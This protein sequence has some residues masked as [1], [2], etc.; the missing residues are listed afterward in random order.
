MMQGFRGDGVDD[1]CGR[2]IGGEMSS[3]VDV[4]RML[5]KRARHEDCVLFTNEMSCLMWQNH[6]ANRTAKLD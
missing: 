4:A 3:W 1:V 6:V 2:N 5:A